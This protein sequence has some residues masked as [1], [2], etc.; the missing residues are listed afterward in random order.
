MVGSSMKCVKDR[1]MTCQH[2]FSPWFGPVLKC[3]QCGA[4]TMLSMDPKESK[5]IFPPLEAP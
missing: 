1:W 5:P 4:T 3:I 2:R